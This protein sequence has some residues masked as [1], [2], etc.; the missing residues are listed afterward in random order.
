MRRALTFTL[1]LSALPLLA[2]C[3]ED[4]EGS[5]CVWSVQSDRLVLTK[6]GGHLLRSPHLYL[7]YYWGAGKRS[8]LTRSCLHPYSRLHSLFGSGSV[9]VTA[10]FHPCIAIKKAEYR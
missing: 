8:W 2:A 1:A 6:I 4:P 7:N 9:Q 5:G 3:V 10:Y